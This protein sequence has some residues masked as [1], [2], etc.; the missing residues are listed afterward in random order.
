MVADEG[1][2]LIMILQRKNLLFIFQKDG[3][4]SGQF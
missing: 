1:N 2:L 4:L 3:G